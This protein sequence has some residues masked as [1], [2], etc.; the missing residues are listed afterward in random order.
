MTEK[1]TRK[2]ER[3]EGKNKK[4][5]K[6]E[7]KTQAIKPKKWQTENERKAAQKKRERK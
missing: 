6:N 2:L 4:E 1:K 3:T 7:K 5:G